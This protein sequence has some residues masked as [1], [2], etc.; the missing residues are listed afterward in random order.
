MRKSQRLAKTSWLAE[1]VG[2]GIDFF[3]NKTRAEPS[4]GCEA[5]E[6]SQFTNNGRR[7]DRT[8]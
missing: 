2:H 3:L 7:N 1:A 4:N 8:I 6:S 5:V